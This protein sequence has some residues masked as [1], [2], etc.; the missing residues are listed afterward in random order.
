M[1]I[2]LVRLVSCPA[3]PHSCHSPQALLTQADKL[4]L[5]LGMP[6]MTLTDNLLA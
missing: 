3:S 2:T 6:L 5:S 1:K 4:T